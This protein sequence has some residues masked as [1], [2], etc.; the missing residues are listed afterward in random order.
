L[1]TIVRNAV[2]DKLWKSMKINIEY[3][4]VNDLA[5]EL[6]DSRFGRGYTTY[7]YPTSRHDAIQKKKL[8]T[9]KSQPIS[10]DQFAHL[11]K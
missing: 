1:E 9:G 7:R 4:S 2:T 6:V 5:P 10:D 3:F 8:K 11:P